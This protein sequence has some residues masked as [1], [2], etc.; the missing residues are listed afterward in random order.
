MDDATGTVELA[1]GDDELPLMLDPVALRSADL[2]VQK[3][4][5]VQSPS[6]LR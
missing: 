5:Q 6:H 1:I 2:D 3:W 4:Y